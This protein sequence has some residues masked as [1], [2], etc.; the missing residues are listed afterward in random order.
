LCSLTPG[1]GRGR[2]PKS[3]H[4]GY[5]DLAQAATGVMVRF[6]GGPDTPEEH[7]HFGTIDALTGF[8]ACVALG[9]ALERRRLTGKG[10]VARA[11]LGGCGRD[12][13]GAVHV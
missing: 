9:A 6:G 5:D 8:A 3:D 1:A 12:D 10:G 7:A 13:P 2:G 11:A 4:L